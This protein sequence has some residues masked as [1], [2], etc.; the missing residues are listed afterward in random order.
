MMDDKKYCLNAKQKN[1]FI[2]S[3]VQYKFVETQR[4]K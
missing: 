1:N 2:V 4:Y 3:D